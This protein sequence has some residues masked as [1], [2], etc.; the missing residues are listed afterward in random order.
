MDESEFKHHA[1]TVIEAARKL[2]H[3][4][5]RSEIVVYKGS[6][7][8]WLKIEIWPFE[9]N[10]STAC[11]LVENDSRNNIYNA[12]ADLL[13]AVDAYTEWEAEAEGMSDE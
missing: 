8:Q 9:N 1:S 4:H 7:Q 13:G 12:L 3:G 5:V 11:F 2:V 6:Q 10:D